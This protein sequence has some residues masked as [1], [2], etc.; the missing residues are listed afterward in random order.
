LPDSIEYLSIG[1]DTFN[2]GGLPLNSDL[3][4]KLKYLSLGSSFTNGGVKIIRTENMKTL[5]IGENKI[6]S[7]NNLQ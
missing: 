6:I 4:H 7:K 2:N 5:I 3:L 1:G